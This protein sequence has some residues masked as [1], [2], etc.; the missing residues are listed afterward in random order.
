MSVSDRIKELKNAAGLT[1]AELSEKS[2]VPIGTLNKIL[3]NSTT[4]VKVETLGAISVALGVSPSFLMEE[5]RDREEDKKCPF[6]DFKRVAAITPEN[7]KLGDVDNN[8]NEIISSLKRLAASKADVVVFPELTLSG[9]TLSDLFYHGVLLDKCKQAL[10]KLAD[11]SVN[12]DMIFFVGCPLKKDGRLYN[13]AVSISGGKILGVVPK[14]FLPN[15]NEFY[16]RRQFSSLGDKPNTTIEIGG[17]NYPFGADLIFCEKGGDLKISA[18]ICE[19]LWVA[20]SP[21][22]KH[23]LAGANLIVNLSAGDELIGKAEYRRNLVSMQS[24]KCICAYAYSSAGFGES[25]TDMVFS[26]HNMIYENGKKLAE[27][28]LFGDGFAISDIDVSLLS[29]ERNK[30]ADYENRFSSSHENIYFSLGAKRDEIL[31][32]YSKTPFIPSDENELE[33]RINLILNIQSTGLMRRI[34]HINCKTLVIGVSGGLDSTLALLVA[35]RAMDRLK[36]PRADV[37]GVTMPCFG[38]T[39]RTKNNSILLMKE[40]GVTAREIDISNTVRSHFKDIGQSETQTDVTYE[41]SQ[42]RER[43]QVIMDIANMTGGIVVGTGDLSELALGWATY[44]GDHM[45]MYGVNASI[46]KTLVKYIVKHVAKRTGGKTEKILFDILDTPVSPELIP[47]DENGE[48]KQKTEDLVGPYI[49]HDFFLYHFIRS[50]YSPSKIYLI[51]LNTFSGDF[52][53]KEIYKWLE[54]FVGRFFSQQFKRSCLPDGVK[55]GSVSLSPR[56]DWRMPSDVSAKVWLDD[57]KKVK[58]E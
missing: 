19:D 46:P 35:V 42:A 50:G 55:V 45:S 2:G 18:E 1:T 9:Y 33:E 43:T 26:A 15:Y 25:S 41:N 28:K 29:F 48:I 12:L 27:S 39:K 14:T 17:E 47:A 22:I 54:K 4:S 10:L 53:D 8:L 32:K 6:P 24:A 13:T 58:P 30:T 56:G 38:T 49:L 57:L 37:I 7:L 34:S 20:N 3:S 52:T 5:G 36:R 31:R 40:L 23:C 21:S 44:N 11:F 16:E 51:A